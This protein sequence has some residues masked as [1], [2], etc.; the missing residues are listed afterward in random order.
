MDEHKRNLVIAA[1][2][3]IAYYGV[4]LALRRLTRYRFAD[5]RV[6]I[7]GGSRGLG[8]ILA[9]KLVEQGAHVAICARDQEELESAEKELSGGPGTI[10][11]LQCDV[12]SRTDVEAMAAIVTEKL[13]GIDVLINNAGVIQVG[14]FESMTVEDFEETMK[15]HFWGPLYATLAVTPAMRAQGEGRIVNIASIGGKVSIPHLLPY[16]A[17]KFALVGLSEGLRMELA[18]DGIVVT[19]VCPGLMRTGSHSHAM[20]KGEHSAEYT[21]FSLLDTLPL[22]SV[23]ADRAADQIIAAVRQGRS[24]L[25]ISPQAQMLQKLHEMFPG[26]FADILA[27]INEFLLPP[28]VKSSQKKQGSQIDADLVPSWLTTLGDAAAV[29]N[30]ELASLQQG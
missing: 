24:E 28:G 21:W 16:C 15:T 19:T 27:I 22:T 5:Q 29:E 26:P 6:L 25:I 3:G 23:S 13:G 1:A 18:K 11:T 10:M 9:R 2:A 20:V 12:T 8:F 30:N 7:T 4:R 17:S 14:P